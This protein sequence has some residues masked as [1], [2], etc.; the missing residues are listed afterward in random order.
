MLSI[1]VIFDYNQSVMSQL[2]IV[3]CPKCEQWGNR[4]GKDDDKCEHCGEYLEPARFVHAEEVRVEED[5]RKDNYLVLKDS[6]ETIVQLGKLFVNAMR[7]GS[8]FGAVLFF[9]AITV[10]LVIF[11]LI[12]I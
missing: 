10:M 9:I 8:Y 6:D 1:L 4:A 5:K 7:W 3:K 2:N 12:A 11:G